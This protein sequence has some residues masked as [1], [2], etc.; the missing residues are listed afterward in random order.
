MSSMSLFFLAFLQAL[1]RLV[2]ALFGGARRQADPEDGNFLA[3]HFPAKNTAVVADPIVTFQPNF[4]GVPALALSSMTVGAAFAPD[5]PI[6]IKAAQFP[7]ALEKPIIMLTSPTLEDLRIIE[8]EIIKTRLPLGSITN[9]AHRVRGRTP[10]KPRGH[11]KENIA[12]HPSAPR[13]THPRIVYPAPP[14]P[15]RPSTVRLPALG[16]HRAA[17]AKSLKAA[18]PASL[19]WENE[20]ALHLKQARQWSDAVKARRQ[21]LPAPSSPSYES[22][23]AN[24]RASAPIRLPLDQRLRNAVA[25]CASPPV[26][27]PATAKDALP[28]AVM[29]TLPRPGS[30]TSLESAS[31]S[32][33]T[34]SV[35]ACVL[36]EFEAD[37]ESAVWMGLRR[38][39]GGSDEKTLR[40]NCGVYGR[41][42]E[43]GQG[44]NFDDEESSGDSHWSDVVS[45][46]DY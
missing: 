11:D 39:G 2:R 41:K 32:A 42:E 37:L 27:V 38:F 24:R 16:S 1:W 46:E 5:G 12:T 9:T 34:E 13:P 45:L 20:K 14:P 30:S 8:K 28:D 43:R 10:R 15:L 36:E 22:K 21:S 35:L 25:G 17:N 40:R 3:V 26:V 18:Q 19:Q 4:T 6:S 29:Y 31:S 23:T 44:D 7:S 33:S